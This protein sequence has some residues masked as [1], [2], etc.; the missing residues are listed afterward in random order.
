MMTLANYTALRAY[1]YTPGNETV[2]VQGYLAIGDGGE[3]HFYWDSLKTD[4]DN[5]GTIIKVNTV[6]TGRWRRLYDGKL[7]VKWF[8]AKGDGVSDDTNSIQHA[9]NTS[10]GLSQTLYMPSGSYRIASYTESEAY[11]YGGGEPVITSFGLI[12]NGDI[13]L[14]LGKSC[15]LLFDAPSPGGN[16]YGGIQ[17]KGNTKITGLGTDS[18]AGVFKMVKTDKISGRLLHFEGTRNQKISL[19]ISGVKLAGGYYQICLYDYIDGC[20][21]DNNIFDAT[22]GVGGYGVFADDCRWF[23][24]VRITNNTFIGSNTG[25]AIEINNDGATIKGIHP[26]PNK[27]DRTADEWSERLW[28]S[29]NSISNYTDPGQAGGIGIGLAG[30]MTDVFI[31]NNTV[32]NCN[33]GIHFEFCRYKPSETLQN[34]SI[35]S[36]KVTNNN[37]NA[38]FVYQSA[39][40]MSNAGGMLPPESVQ[41]MNIVCAHNTFESS[42]AFPGYIV[43][44]KGIRGMH[45]VNNYV[46]VRDILFPNYAPSFGIAQDGT[47]STLVSGNIIYN[48]TYAI[49]F[50]GGQSSGSNVN[51]GIVNNK[52]IDC[53]YVYY[54]DEFIYSMGEINIAGNQINGC[55]SMLKCSTTAVGL[56]LLANNEKISGLKFDKVI[57]TDDGNLGIRRGVRNDAFDFSSPNAILAD[58]IQSNYRGDCYFV[59]N[60]LQNMAGG[61]M[62]ITVAGSLYDWYDHANLAVYGTK[63]SNFLTFAD[64]LSLPA[65][66]TE[67]KIIKIAGYDFGGQ[68]PFIYR[69][70]DSARKIYLTVNLTSDI[71][72]QIMS[73]QAATFIAD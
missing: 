15:S 70:D 36:N 44:L 56:I 7:N 16:Q 5:D 65:V 26:D 39:L 30:K 72:N 17:F 50:A 9:I 34:I 4:A 2:F 46:G 68:M 33:Q 53:K 47:S 42:S 48:L 60:I 37:T 41:Q 59:G 28:I 19:T 57:Y 27:T 35:T 11:I 61:F 55:S 62:R 18:N 20:L 23:K 73:L 24:N 71:V 6:A 25:D 63:G 31:E 32:D 38:N 13:S 43:G 8:G 29:N 51:K 52:I 58:F 22:K 10:S 40:S 66:V 12:I 14:E 54:L 1:S 49:A 3:G 21:I 69:I 64:G 67:G 45:F